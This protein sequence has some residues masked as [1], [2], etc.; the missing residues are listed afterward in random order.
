M[1]SSWLLFPAI[2]LALSFGAG[3]LAEHFARVRL[4]AALLVPLGFG[5]ITVV[6]QLTTAVD[7]MAELTTPLVVVLALA[8][9][10]LARERVGRVRPDP[11]LAGAFLVVM[12]AY[13][14]PVIVSGEPTFLGYIRLDDTATWLALTD[15]IMEH[16][17]SLD[18]L[19]P[20]SYEATLAVN[21]GAGYPVG[22]FVP[23][24]IGAELTGIDPAWLIQPYITLIAATLALVLWD[25]LRDPIERP[26][27]RAVAVAIA[28]QPALLVGYAQWGGVKEVAAA[29]LVA[30]CAALAIRVA[31]I[32]STA[33]G[34]AA[35]A[36]SVSALLAVLSLG[37]LIWVIPMLL[38]A[39]WLVW[40]R[41]GHAAVVRRA[42]LF[43]GTTCLLSSPLLL[44]LFAEGRLLPPTSSSLAGGTAQGNLIAPLGLERLAGVWPAG[45]FRLDAVG[46]PAAAFLCA[47]AFAAAI[48]GAAV[49]LRDW[50]RA[51][52]LFGFGTLAGFAVIYAVG[53]P[54]VG[55]KALAT[56]SPAVLALAV[57]GACSLAGR[58]RLV[59]IAV[60]ATLIA[61]VGWS[62]ALAYRDANLAP[63]DQLAELELIGEQISGE[64]PTLM[65]EYQP[66]GVRH[67]LRGADP[68]GVSELR[69][70]SI[71]LRDGSLVPKGEWA[72]IAELDPQAVRA[73][74]TLVLRK[75]PE[76]TR[77]PDGYELV[78]ASEH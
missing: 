77:P 47:A 49:V 5:G 72:D 50:H 20:S 59:G 27:A 10:A 63:Y 23:L 61:G 17:H 42:A 43:A 69:R 18:G 74:R 76:Q 73:Y 8:G 67:F 62:N 44:S 16:G 1:T 46:G 30:L 7:A 25:L 28:A 6:G 29:T 21:L 38:A 4:P 37:G 53:S 64:G 40:R 32:G 24:G 19:A 11:W 75:S 26:A 35:L 39:A 78:E 71:P 33:G 3:L 31:A 68:E 9:L 48:F 34:S 41:A 54:W 45:D 52:A 51:M 2:L 70:R 65:T 58:S 22:V 55:G 15:R 13:G 60:L 56:A 66:Y 12:L 36:V 57:V 14:A